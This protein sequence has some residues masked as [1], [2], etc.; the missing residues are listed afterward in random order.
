MSNKE[1]K[2]PESSSSVPGC[3]GINSWSVESS[4]PRQ[5]ATRS[6]RSVTRAFSAKA[7]EAHSEGYKNEHS[8]DSVKGSISVT[9]NHFATMD[10]VNDVSPPSEFQHI[11]AT[12]K[13]SSSQRCQAASRQAMN[14]VTQPTGKSTRQKR[15]R[16]ERMKRRKQDTMMRQ[17]RADE[18]DSAQI[19]SE[20]TL[21]NNH[22]Y[23]DG[24]KESNPPI[25]PVQPRKATKEAIVG[26][27]RSKDVHV[28]KDTLDGAI[29]RPEAN[30]DPLWILPPRTCNLE[31]TGDDP[32]EL[33]SSLHHLEKATN[34]NHNRGADKNVMHQSHGTK[35]CCAGVRPNRNKPG[36]EPSVN[37]EKVD[38][39]SWNC[40]VDYV[41]R[42]ET[43]FT[44]W[45]DTNIL[46]AVRHAKKLV[47]F[48]SL[49]R[50]NGSD[51]LPASIF[52]SVAFGLNVYLNAHKDKDFVYSIVCVHRPL[53]DGKKSYEHD[54]DVVCYFVFPRYG[55][56]VPLRPGDIL[57]FN[58]CEYH[59]ISSRVSDEDDFYCLSLYLKTEVVGQH[60]NSIPLTDEQKEYAEA[61]KNLKKKST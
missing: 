29:F 27:I 28:V 48:L 6:T 15:L 7:D 58:P 34:N 10:K 46:R 60:D 57:I 20:E 32:T 59:C 31:V 21:V 36:V 45:I 17:V 44:K 50:Q 23:F 41:I 40:I 13:T 1:T 26:K 52:G 25:A 61:Y 5:T 55:M 14:A 53:T 22:V 47:N 24:G 54:D 9:S 42:C 3:G 19:Y 49:P 8:S 30:G 38:E 16:R 39:R 11:Y 18:V 56:A 35:Y 43:A 51:L 12:T 37:V 33:I 4:P 2:I